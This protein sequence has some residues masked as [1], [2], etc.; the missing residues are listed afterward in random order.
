MSIQAKQAAVFAATRWELNAVRRTLEVEKRDAT[1]GV[2]TLLGRRGLYRLYLV[3]TGVGSDKARTASRAALAGRSFDLA[4]VTGFTGALT[5]AAVGDL[6]IATEVVA[7]PSWDGDA[8]FGPALACSPHVAALALCSARSAGLAARTGRF[9]TVPWVVSR[10][11]DKREL[12]ARAEAIGLDMESAAVC[13][14]AQAEGVPVLVVR[15]VSD[16]LDE[17]LPLDFNCFLRPGDW[18]R[19]AV[20]CLTHPAALVGLNRLRGQARLGAARLTAF[21]GR[22]FD[23]LE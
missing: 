21:F 18:A 16:L 23:D 17:D 3:R 1:S 7:C 9:V 13:E 8:G 10:S 5:P 4:V 22:F 14:A 15:A 2:P 19:G 11:R 20:A 12:A 6:L